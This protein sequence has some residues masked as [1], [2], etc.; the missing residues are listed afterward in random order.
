MGSSEKYYFE[1]TSGLDDVAM[2]QGA[3]KTSLNVLL[4][5]ITTSS[6]SEPMTVIHIMLHIAKTTQG[7][8]VSG[9]Y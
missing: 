8:R 9:C 5:M 2:S 6:Q 7:S 1:A 3:W 4:G